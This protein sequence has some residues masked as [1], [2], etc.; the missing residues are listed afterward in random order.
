MSRDLIRLRILKQLIASY[1]GN[2]PLNLFLQEQFRLNKSWGSSDRR[3]YREWVYA[4]MRLGT[5]A[6][7][8]TL[9][10]AL[11]LLAIKKNE[12]SLV[13]AWSE[14][15]VTAEQR[16]SEVF[17][18][19]K[20][21]NWFPYHHLVSEHI[22]IEALQAHHQHVLPVYA[23]ILPKAEKGTM[24]LPEGAQLLPD[25][26][27]SFPSATDLSLWVKQGFLQIQ[28]LGSQSICRHIAQHIAE[29]LFWDACAGAG[30]KS[31]YFAPLVQPHQLF[32]SDQRNGSLNNLL[33]R[34]EQAG[35]QQP[36]YAVVDLEQEHVSLEFSK[37][38]ESKVVL[39]EHMVDYV[40]LDVPCSGS[41]TWGRSPEMLRTQFNKSAPEDY[42]R[43]QRTIVSNALHFLKPGGLLFYSTCSVYRC[44][45]EENTTFFQ[46]SFNLTLKEFTYIDGYHNHCDYLYLAVLQK[47]S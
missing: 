45:N 16:I 15:T 14:G 42:A 9:Q 10:D 47:Q 25:G 23:R 12:S 8:L 13:E 2:Q 29:G 4:Y 44:E 40:A 28:D 3:F 31:L 7:Q 5:A 18:E 32:C 36:F 24:N 22:P 39:S 38:H 17:P 11:L 1:T 33:E 34:F 35:F 19:Y 6:D 30:G 21:Q 27:L 37:A 46:E 43:K 41:G 20:E 26:A